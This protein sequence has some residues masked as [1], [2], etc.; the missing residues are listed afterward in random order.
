MSYTH[1]I[2]TSGDDVVSYAGAPPAGRAGVMVNAGDG[3]DRI[4]GSSGDDRLNGGEGS[5]SLDGG[6]GRDF[7]RGGE[8]AD[9]VRGGEGND[10]FIFHKGDL[11]AASGNNKVNVDHIVDFAGQGGYSNQG[12]GDFI[13]FWGFGPGA[14]LEFSHYGSQG[15]HFQYYTVTDDTGTYDLLVQMKDG[16]GRTLQLGDYA[17]YNA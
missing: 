7:L 9:R 2:L 4:I 15:Q 16:S 5:D 17:F 8:G 6:A 14:K 3:N 12:E 10:T 13:T 1:T 11:V